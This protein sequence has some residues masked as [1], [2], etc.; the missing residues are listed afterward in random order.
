MTGDQPQAWSRRQ[1]WALLAG[2]CVVGVALLV[3]LGFAI[4]TAV[5]HATRTTTQQ[6]RPARLRGGW[7][8]MR[9]WP[10]RCCRWR[11][12]MRWVVLRRW[13]PRRR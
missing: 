9:C 13:S 2:L 4:R 1:L 11:R 8:G 6:R 3:G 5:V 12:R 7:I 10:R